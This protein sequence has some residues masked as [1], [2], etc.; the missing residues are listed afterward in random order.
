M[1]YA[2]NVTGIDISASASDVVRLR[3]LSIEGTGLAGNGVSVFQVGALRIEQC[4][5]FG[6]NGTGIDFGVNPGVGSELYVSD[7]LISENGT[8]GATSGIFVTTV[9]TGTARVS[10]SNVKLDNNRTGLYVNTVPGSTGRI[11]LSMRNSTAAGNGQSGIQ[12]L[13]QGATI[14]AALNNVTAT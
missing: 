6:F 10:L 1:A 7:S 5:I 12:I 9:G 8:G 2:A 4:K 14:V 11:S 13:A 3:G